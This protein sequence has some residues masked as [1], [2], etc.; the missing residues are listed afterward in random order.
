LSCIIIVAPLAARELLKSQNTAS[1]RGIAEKR[2]A[3]GPTFPQSNEKQTERTKLPQF[4]P[5]FPSR[6]F[7]TTG[8]H[9]FYIK[10]G[11]SF[12][13]LGQFC[14]RFSDRPA[15]PLEPLVICS[16]Q[17][18]PPLHNIGKVKEPG[19]CLAYLVYITF[20]YMIYRNLLVLFF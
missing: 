4:F 6:T 12:A 13:A 7:S 20:S 5:Q 1:G 17:S 19:H 14:T 16:G 9:H 3:G 8:C 10:I 2:E 18:L 11:C 15:F